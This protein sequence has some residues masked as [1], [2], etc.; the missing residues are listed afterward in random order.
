MNT[1]EEVIATVEGTNGAAL[2]VEVPKRDGKGP[3]YEVRFKGKTETFLSM[4][5]AYITAKE[6]AGVKA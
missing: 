2:V 3:S 4:G 5:E 1:T 6:K